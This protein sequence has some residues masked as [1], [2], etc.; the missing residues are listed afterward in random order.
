ME[1]PAR[2]LFITVEGVEGVGKTVLAML[3]LL[4]NIKA[5][6]IA[7]YSKERL[8][9]GILVPYMRGLCTPKGIK[10]LEIQEEL[11]RVSI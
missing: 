9:F 8:T 4:K 11:F 5:F 6:P 10:L 1:K 7:E 3:K 2:G